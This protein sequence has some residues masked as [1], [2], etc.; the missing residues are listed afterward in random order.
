MSCSPSRPR[1]LFRLRSRCAALI[2]P[3]IL[4]PTSDNP[5]PLGYTWSL[6]LFVIPIGVLAWWFACRPDLQFPRK[7][8]WRTIAVLAPLGILARSTLWK[9]FLH[10]PEQ[11]RHIRLRNSRHWRIDSNRGIRFLPH[12]FHAR[13]AELHLV[14]RILDGGLQRARLQ[15]GSG[16]NSAHC[17]FSFCFRNSWRRPDRRGD[18]VP[19]V[20]IRRARRIPVVFRLSRLCRPY[21]IGRIFS[22]RP[23][24]HQ[25]AR[26]QFYFFSPASDQ[27][28]LGSH[29]G[30]ALW[31]V[32]IQTA[33]SSWVAHW[34][35]VRSAHRS[36]MPLDGGEFYHGD[37]L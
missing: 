20:L 7:A 1:L 2:H 11:G 34:S 6:L 3:G 36:G 24:V 15:N 8:F 18:S 4:Q 27:L 14:R 16:R 17:P 32:G 33:H 22:Y 31:L 35:M 30:L 19:K 21:S 26:V 28:A 25:L 5:T 37:H 23:T 12:W 29:A 9:C 10:F 13:A